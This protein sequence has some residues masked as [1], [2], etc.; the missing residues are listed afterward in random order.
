MVVHGTLIAATI[1]TTTPMDKIEMLGALLEL[2]VG[3]ETIRT[4]L[5]LVIHMEIIIM[6]M[7]TTIITRQAQVLET[8]MVLRTIAPATMLTMCCMASIRLR[9]LIKASYL[10]IKLL[11]IKLRTSVILQYL[12]P[13]LLAILETLE[14]MSLSK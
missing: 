13:P 11:T 4:I 10:G 12:G 9:K 5:V 3:M 1:T 7:G 14:L 8:L 2:Q 6:L